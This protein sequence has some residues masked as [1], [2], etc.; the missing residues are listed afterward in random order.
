ME[1]STIVYGDRM[2]WRS[3]TYKLIKGQLWTIWMNF[4]NCDD[5]E[6]FE[7][8]LNEI[9]MIVKW[10]LHRPRHVDFKIFY[11]RLS[12]ISTDNH[13][14]GWKYSIIFSHVCS[15]LF[16]CWT[17]CVIRC[18]LYGLKKVKVLEHVLI[19][20]HSPNTINTIHNFK[21]VHNENQ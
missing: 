19:C 15:W 13:A 11:M 1:Y 2:Q 16:T 8:I 3:R 21:Y 4:T 5:R 20:W 6:Q 9:C 12:Q 18:D 17:S 10:F 7:K 14:S